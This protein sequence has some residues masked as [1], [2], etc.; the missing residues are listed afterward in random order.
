MDN[1]WETVNTQL[2]ELRK[3][4]NADDVIRILARERN[5]YGAGHG[6]ERPLRHGRI[7]GGGRHP[8]A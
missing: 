2:A 7:P 4:E 8:G 5:P 6:E 1:F 3:A